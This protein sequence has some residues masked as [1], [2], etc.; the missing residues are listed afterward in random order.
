MLKETAHKPNPVKIQ[1]PLKNFQ[2]HNASCY[3]IIQQ[4]PPIR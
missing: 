1:S 3:R 2:R 4:D